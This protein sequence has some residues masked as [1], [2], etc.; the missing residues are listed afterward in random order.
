M[1]GGYSGG[2]GEF[3]LGQGFIVKRETKEQQ[4]SVVLWRGKLTSVATEMVK[5]KNGL[6]WWGKG[7]VVATLELGRGK[8]MHARS[9]C[10]LG[11]R[12]AGL[13]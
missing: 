2:K 8:G 10:W 4:L 7:L 3:S 6:A 5:A 9:P 1:H 13:R 12:L 11:L